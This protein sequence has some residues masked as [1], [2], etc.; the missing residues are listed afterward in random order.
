MKKIGVVVFPG[1][2][3][4][5]DAVYAATHHGMTAKKIWHQDSRLGDVDAV[6]LPGGFSY[7]DYLRCGAIA[8]LSPIMTDVVRF[9]NAGGPVLGICNGFQILVESGLLPGALLRNRDLH[10]ICKTVTVRLEATDT[11][12][13]KAGKAN[14]AL[15][16][17]IAHMDGNYFIDDDG[18]QRLE[19]N[20]QVIFRYCDD[21]GSTTPE[22][23]P[24][25]SCHNIAGVCNTARNVV[26][27]MPH[28][29]RVS[30]ALLGGND[31]VF[32]F[33][34]LRNA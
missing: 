30:D 23:N 6:I 9:A 33:E 10:F 15:R 29:E 7:G 17:P 4:D 2:N 21:S 34:S 5:D 32:I 20:R 22:S 8:K 19:D 28:P 31:G 26:G 16:L 18:L 13:T 11:P 1:S 27:L 14:T 12:F 25:G 24:N 3:C